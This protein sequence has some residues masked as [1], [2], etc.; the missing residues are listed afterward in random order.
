MNRDPVDLLWELSQIDSSDLD[1]QADGD[2]LSGEVLEAWRAGRLGAAEAARVEGVL[3][4][5][6]AAR[7]QLYRLGSVEQ[8]SPP[9]GLR[10]RVMASVAAD[11]QPPSSSR[12][13][14]LRGFISQFAALAAASLLALGAYVL[15][16]GGGLISGDGLESPIASSVQLPADMEFD[17]G[18]EMLAETR[19]GDSE[20]NSGDA[21]ARTRV[22]IVI[23]PQE[24]AQAGL[25]FGLYRERG[26]VLER[27]LP[28]EEIRLETGRGTAVFEAPASALVGPEPGAR[29]LLVA[30]AAV[31]NLP[32][33]LRLPAGEKAVTALVTR[34]GAKVYRR[35]IRVLEEPESMES[36][37]MGSSPATPRPDLERMESKKT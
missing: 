6:A 8:P 10:S 11:D 12:G 35:T 2:R 24:Q 33:A 15:S 7:E 37:P 14:S 34:A 27:L 25:E 20:S 28:G 17:V 32:T 22:R 26:E 19:S 5:D 29:D 4:H 36:V 23:E 21:Y 1:A 13:P 18:L 31:G 16:Q 30:V 3:A 9:A